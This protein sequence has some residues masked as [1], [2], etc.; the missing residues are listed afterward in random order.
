VVPFKWLPFSFEEII[1]AHKNNIAFVRIWKTWVKLSLSR[2]EIGR[3]NFE[4]VK[5]ADDIPKHV[6]KARLV[7]VRDGAWLG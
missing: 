7:V 3:M 1:P 5:A 2:V 6:P 4:R